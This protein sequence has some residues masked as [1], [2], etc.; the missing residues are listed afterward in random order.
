MISYDFEYA[1][2][3]T[4]DEALDQFQ[5]FEKQGKNPIYFSGGTEIITLGRKNRIV[6]NAVI[7]IKAIPECTVIQK[8]EGKL[9]LG[10][11]LSLTEV[12]EQN[13]FPLLSEI[14]MEIAD[15]TARNKITLGGNICSNIVY[16][17]A[18]LPFLLTESEAM[19]A[20]K[21]GLERRPFTKRFNQQLQLGQGEFLVQV[22]TKESDLTLPFLTMKK[23]KQWDVG[24]PLLTTAALQ[25]ESRV[26]VAF[27]GLCAFPF[28]NEQLEHRL[29]ACQLSNDE[30]IEQAIREV[31]T[32]L[33]D[34]VHGSAE[35]RKFVL[36]NS[37]MD[38]LN[39]FEGADRRW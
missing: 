28:R 36:K 9:V 15:N 3:A 25:K 23:R 13:V 5:T 38:V 7:D 18:V 29:N 12:I 39:A 1:K 26:K 19:I 6:T 34:D 10:A 24:Y 11:A 27:S 8:Q 37:L 33:L 31:D 4:I 21:K 35:Y 20:T 22:T 32:P 16:K 30:R 14:A 2:P 17:E